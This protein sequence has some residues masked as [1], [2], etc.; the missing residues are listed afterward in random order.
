MT[1][2]LVSILIQMWLLFQETSNS[3]H[4]TSILY[5]NDYH[6]DFQGGRFIFID[7]NEVDNRTTYSSIEPKKGRITVFTSGTENQH[8]VEKV[9]QGSRWDIITWCSVHWMKEWID[10]VDSTVNCFKCWITISVS[11]MRW[12]YHSRAIVNL[13][14]PMIQLNRKK[15]TENK[16]H[17]RSGNIPV[18]TTLN[19]ICFEDQKF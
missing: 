17:S 1:A 11:D 8:H 3:F 12:Q 2:N 13:P 10:S 6:R 9:T 7:E 16:S 18:L 5:L 19:A 14:S 4:Y 15:L